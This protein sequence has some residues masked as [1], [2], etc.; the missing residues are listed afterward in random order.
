MR[1]VA[2]GLV[3]LS[4]ALVAAGCGDSSGGG[5]TTTSGT[6]TSSEAAGGGSDAV[7]WAD[8]VCSGIKDDIA[9]LT[10]TP[11]LDSSDPQAA[12]D[13]LIAY[14]GTLE[15]SLDGM[16]SAVQDAGAPPVDGGDEAVKT[17]VDQISTAK[18]AVTSAKG[19]IEAAPVTDP[20]AFQAAAAGAMSD[21]AALGELDPT[22]AL[23]ANKELS[24]AYDKAPECQ[25]LEVGGSTPTS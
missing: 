6:N 12:K 1:R 17:F 24:A 25:K 7:A 9:A 15:T 19:K 5:S 3:A 4:L 18:D 8:K 14:F 23:S 10:Q 22:T 16:A 2:T 13:G 21:L 20:A 11:D